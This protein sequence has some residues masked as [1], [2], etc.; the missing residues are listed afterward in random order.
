MPRTADDEI[1]WVGDED[2]N[3]INSEYKE[4]KQ[5]LKVWS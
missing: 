2:I 5:H 4:N 3:K 1:I